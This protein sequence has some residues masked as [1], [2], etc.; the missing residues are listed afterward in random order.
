[1]NFTINKLE[2]WLVPIPSTRD[3]T[4]CLYVRQLA[5]CLAFPLSG[6]SSLRSVLL[7]AQNMGRCPKSQLLFCLDIK[8]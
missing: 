7:L 3:G 6:I 5:D 2:V 4:R 8:K 1:M